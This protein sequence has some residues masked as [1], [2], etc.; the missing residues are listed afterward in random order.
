MNHIQSQTLDNA[1]LDALVD[2]ELSE[3]AR[4]ALL[5]RLDQEPEQWRRVALAFL[6]A[7]AFQAAWRGKE[8]PSPMSQRMEP[9]AIALHPSP[10]AARSRF[11]WS[12]LA[13][14]AA[15]LLLAFSTGWMMHGNGREST[16]ATTSSTSPQVQ[17]SNQSPSPVVSPVKTAFSNQVTA[18]LRQQLLRLGYEV[19]EQPRL[20]HIQQDGRSI[21]VYVNDLK[22]RFVGRREVL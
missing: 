17:A 20:I 15:A 13:M 12:G 19:H 16:L 9:S 14:L 5:I 18:E 21:P 11:T 4:H 3:S 22:V 2:G 1:T 6:E 8:F 7:Q 10:A